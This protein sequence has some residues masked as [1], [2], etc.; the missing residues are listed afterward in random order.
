MSKDGVKVWIRQVLWTRECTAFWTHWALHSTW[1]YWKV[2]VK[3]GWLHSSK[4]PSEKLSKLVTCLARFLFPEFLHMSWINKMCL[5]CI[6]STYMCIISLLL[7]AW[8]YLFTLGSGFGASTKA[9]CLGMRYWKP[10]RLES[11]IEVSIECG[12]MTHNHPTGNVR[13]RIGA[14]KSLSLLFT[15]GQTNM[16]PVNSLG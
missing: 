16:A 6:L 4:I 15:A 1:E 3:P 2:P 7:K 13:R 10:E 11:L 14:L 5:F 8:H 12:R 9:M